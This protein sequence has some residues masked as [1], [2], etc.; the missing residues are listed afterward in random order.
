[1]LNVVA[2]VTSLNV[3]VTSLPGHVVPP[4]SIR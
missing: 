1:M 3:W 2:P 4:P